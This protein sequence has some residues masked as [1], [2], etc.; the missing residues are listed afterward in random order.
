V[1]FG[2]QLEQEQ[3]QPCTCESGHRDCFGGGFPHCCCYL[4]WAGSAATPWNAQIS[5]LFPRRCRRFQKL[6]ASRS[7]QLVD[8]KHV[9]RLSNGRSSSFSPREKENGNKGKRPPIPCNGH[10]SPDKTMEQGLPAPS[11]AQ[12]DTNDA[13]YHGDSLRSILLRLHMPQNP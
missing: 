9:Y 6:L 13:Q 12:E 3:S 4:M 8:R 10:G 11:P 1:K 5:K 2:L 7:P